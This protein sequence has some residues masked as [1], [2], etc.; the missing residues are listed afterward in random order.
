MFDRKKYKSFSKQQLKG[1]WGIPIIITIISGIVGLLFQIPDMY[2]LFNSNEFLLMCTGQYGSIY[3]LFDLY[4]QATS[5]SFSFISTII[6]SIVISIFSF[7]GINVYLKLSRSPEPISFSAFLDGMNK[8]AKA[9]LSFLWQF[10][11]VFLWSFL[12][13]IPGIIKAISYSMMDYLLNEYDDLSI[14]KA[15]R[16]SMIITRGHKWDLFVLALSFI[17]WELLS[18][19]TFGILY[20]Y[21]KPYEEMSFVNAYHAIL[22]EAFERGIIH[23][24]DFE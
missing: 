20:L 10:L 3:E 19:L 21:V 12:L 17:G 1:R 2:R 8:W 24:E 4:N 5:S 18:C 15:M 22:T 6:S 11:W 23:P 7:A 13:F 9:T 16:I 14:T